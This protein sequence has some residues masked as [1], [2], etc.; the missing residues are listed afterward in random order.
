MNTNTQ[1][2]ARMAGELEQE[3]AKFKVQLP[4]ERIKNVAAACKEQKRDFEACRYLLGVG[5]QS[6]F[7]YVLVVSSELSPTAAVAAAATAAGAG[8]LRLGTAGL[9]GVEEKVVAFC[10]V[11]AVIF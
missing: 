9:G 11:Y 4:A 8:F 10:D 5:L 3:A 1:Q 6:L 2:L 7:V